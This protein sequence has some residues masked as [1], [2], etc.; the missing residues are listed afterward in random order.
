[1]PVDPLIKSYYSNRVNFKYPKVK[2]EISKAKKMVTEVLA[3]SKASKED[4]DIMVFERMEYD[5][6]DNTFSGFAGLKGII[7][8]LNE[9]A[10]KEIKIVIDKPS[11]KLIDANGRSARLVGMQAVE[12]VST[13]AK[14]TGI[15]FVGIYNSTYHGILETY[16]RAIAA[17]DLVAIVSANGG[18]QGVVPFGG[19][20]EIFGTNPL[21]YGV[22]TTEL[23]IVFDGAT[24][25]FPYG[26]MHL[27][28]ERNEQL[29]EQTFLTQTGEYTTNPADAYAV[30]PFGG[31]K[32]YALNLLL[33]IMTGNLV[34]AKSGLTQS[35]P[36]DLGSFFIAIDPALFQP[37]EEFKKENTKLVQD[38]EAVKP[39]DP[40]QPVRVPGYRSEKL[41]QQMLK[42]GH[43]YIDTN[44]WTEFTKLYEEIT[45]NLLK[46]KFHRKD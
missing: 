34:K 37:I 26:S 30:I 12:L 19:R 39:V 20:T 8:E 13:M 35:T 6:H 29:P 3:T 15:G 38:I 23:P 45:N 31:H 42:E 18:P 44:A 41:K 11:I 4:I 27:A 21:S 9:G 7:K 1:M 10:G 16:S 33:E 17:K 36:A 22:P 14:D 5:F 25:Q 2:V 40:N 32:G 46:Q 28:K 43:I 24:S